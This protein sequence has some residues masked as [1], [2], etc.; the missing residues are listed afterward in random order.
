LKEGV[1]ALTKRFKVVLN[2]KWCKSCGICV[3]FCPKKVFEFTSDGKVRVMREEMCVGCRSCELRCPDY[4]VEV[5]E[6][7]EE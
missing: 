5:R 1:I 4:A 2:T 6:G 3:E 7:E